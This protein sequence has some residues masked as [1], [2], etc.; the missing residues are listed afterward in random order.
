MRALARRLVALLPIRSELLY[1]LAR[2]IVN[3]HDGD[4]DGDM[5]TNGELRFMR[6]CL[7][8]ARVV[9]DGGANV[10][11]WTA[12]ALAINPDASYHCFEPSRLA[13]ERL[14]AR[15]FP[16]NVTCNDFGLSD[17][18]AEARLFL[19]SAACGANS[20]YERVGTGDT[21]RETEMVRLETI[22]AYCQR[23]DIG[24]VD[25]LKLDVEGHEVAALR[26]AV[27][28]LRERRIRV[29]QFEYGGTYIDAGTHLKDVYELIDSVGGYT[30]HK[31]FPDGARRMEYR[32]PLESHLYSNWAII[33]T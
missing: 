20:L 32:Q 15:S 27:R 3:L 10:G 1:R 28:M 7:R 11:D 33:R 18:A 24:A 23:H 12:A 21:Q 19:F 13:F 16:A 31:L 22:D 4:N 30:I 5:R 6:E 14:A 9:F 26:G 8:D 17:S 29:I 2:K 25:F